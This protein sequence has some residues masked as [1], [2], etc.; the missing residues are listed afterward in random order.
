MEVGL[1]P[2]AE[3]VR[4]RITGVITLD[5]LQYNRPVNMTAD[6]SVSTLAQRGRRSQVESYDPD[7]DKLDF[8]LMIHARSPLRI[9]NELIEAELTLDKS[10]LELTGTNQRFGL[11]GLLTT[12]PSGLIHLRQHVFEI[13]EGT[14]R[15]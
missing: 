10:G 13:R 9:K 5:E 1:D 11:R 12:K 2:N 7:D 15:F 8:D 14:V 3:T 4:P 6:V